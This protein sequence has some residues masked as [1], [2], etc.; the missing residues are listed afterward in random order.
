MI[1]FASTY[2]NLLIPAVIEILFEESLYQ[3]DESISQPSLHLSLRVCLKQN[4]SRVISGF[5]GP[6]IINVIISTI[7]GTAQGTIVYKS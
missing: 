5:D 3:V 2:V 4:K 6:A 7:D 1:H